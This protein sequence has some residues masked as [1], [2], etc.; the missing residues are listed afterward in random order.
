M[1][2]PK[3]NLHGFQ[4]GTPCQGIDVASR[5]VF[6]RAGV[7]ILLF[8]DILKIGLRIEQVDHCFLKTMALPCTDI[9]R[10]RGSQDRYNEDRGSLPDNRLL[11]KELPFLVKVREAFPSGCLRQGRL[12]PEACAPAVRLGWK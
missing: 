4:R 8:Q 11:L 6:Q 10:Y 7:K 12:P 5:I 1:A 2:G 3:G 9:R